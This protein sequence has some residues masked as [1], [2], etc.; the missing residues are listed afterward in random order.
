MVVLLEETA[1]ALNGPK[2]VLGRTMVLR[3]LKVKSQ[4]EER[5]NAHF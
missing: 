4:I 3:L 1:M 2:A 5:L